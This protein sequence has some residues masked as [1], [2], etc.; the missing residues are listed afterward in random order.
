MTHT[1][2]QAT[3]I[4]TSS[5]L[6]GTSARYGLAAGVS[7]AIEGARTIMLI[8]EYRRNGILDVDSDTDLS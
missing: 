1:A 7:G 8:R 5:V 6:S 2:A 3:A 4:V